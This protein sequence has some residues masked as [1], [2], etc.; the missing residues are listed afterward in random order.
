MI[1][2]VYTVSNRLGLHAR[3]AS[4]L[5]KTTTRFHSSVKIMKEGQEIDGK[6]IMGLLMLAAGPGT[7]MTIIADGGD[8]AQLITALDDLFA[9][10]FDDDDTEE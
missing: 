10:R 4:L 7:Q 8:E 2:K 9:R 3:P 5:V 6:S 1:E